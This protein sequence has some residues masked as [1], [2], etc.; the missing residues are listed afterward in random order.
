MIRPAYRYA[1]A[2]VRAID[3]DTFVLRIDIGFQVHVE[4]HVR[5]LIPTA[6]AGMHSVQGTT[7]S[8][9]SCG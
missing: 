6:S 3:G 2:L 1:C 8:Q 4:T 9:S 7:R 5:L